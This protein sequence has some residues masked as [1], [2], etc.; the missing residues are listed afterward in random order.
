MTARQFLRVSLHVAHTKRTAVASVC[1]AAAHESSVIGVDYLHLTSN[2]M[3][4]QE[5]EPYVFSFDLDTTNSSVAVV[6][7]KENP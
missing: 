7:G 6:H 1:T 2:D 3:A 4:K 5:E